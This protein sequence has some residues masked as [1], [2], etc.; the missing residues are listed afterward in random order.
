MDTV[1]GNMIK[2]ELIWIPEKGAG[3]FP[4]HNAK[5]D[6]E[7]FNKYVRYERTPIGHKINAFR[8]RIVNKYTKAKVL[9]IGI[10]SGSFIKHRGNCL[11]YDI[12]PKGR[13]WLEKKGLFFDPYRLADFNSIRGITF[14][15]SLE[16]IRK[17][18][19]IFY[20][21]TDQFVFVSIPIFKDLEHLLKSKH[22]RKNEHYYYFTEKG[23][24]EYMANYNFNLLEVRDDEIKCGREDVYTFIFQKKAGKK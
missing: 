15:D 1:I 13:S 10:G 22:L 5:Y 23:F 19:I 3:H 14:F 20:S 7:Y 2:E 21:L 16:H 11:G 6:T 8:K 12:N 24:I 9:D 4:V 18:E 17:P